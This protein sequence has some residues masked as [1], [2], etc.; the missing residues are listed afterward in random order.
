VSGCAG[1]TRVIC[2]LGDFHFTTRH[3]LGFPFYRSAPLFGISTLRPRPAER[4]KDAFQRFNRVR[5]FLSYYYPC[6][7]QP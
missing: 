3:F 6:Q 2:A 4:K 5:H 1:D 7:L